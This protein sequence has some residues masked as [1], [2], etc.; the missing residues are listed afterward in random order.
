MPWYAKVKNVGLFRSNPNIKL[1]DIFRVTKI[2]A[3]DIQCT[4]ALS[5]AGVT[6]NADTV[7]YLTPKTCR[8]IFSKPWY[9]TD[10][11]DKE[12]KGTTDAMVR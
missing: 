3:S 6:P 2:G 7:Y 4:K 1:G 10:E 9:M 8:K 11:F 12:I 5:S